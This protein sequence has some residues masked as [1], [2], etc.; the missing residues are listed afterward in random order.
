[1]NNFKKK[2]NGMLKIRPTKMRLG[3]LVDFRERKRKMENIIGILMEEKGKPAFL[4][5][6]LFIWLLS[7]N[8]NQKVFANWCQ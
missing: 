4:S 1:M 8:I 5:L 3:K 2:K 6:L 7:L